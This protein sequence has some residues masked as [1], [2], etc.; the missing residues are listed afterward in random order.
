MNFSLR[1]VA[2]GYVEPWKS[3]GHTITITDVSVFAHDI[4]NFDGN[5]NLRYWSCAKKMYKFWSGETYVL[6]SNQVMKNFRQRHNKGN[7][8]V[9]LSPLQKLT[10]FN[11]FSFNTIR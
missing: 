8:F 11:P 1:A 9:V 6:I 2:K 5:A 10:D 7:D 4:F 3:T